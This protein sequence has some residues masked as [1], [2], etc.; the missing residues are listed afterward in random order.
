MF[1][2]G[3]CCYCLYQGLSPQRP[4]T[5][6]V[7]RPGDP[8]PCSTLGRPV[9]QSRPHSLGLQCRQTPPDKD[10]GWAELW[11]QQSPGRGRQ[12]PGRD[13]STV[14]GGRTTLFLNPSPPPPSILHPT[15]QP[16][17]LSNPTHPTPPI[18]TTFRYNHSKS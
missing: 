18:A 17:P 7:C 3:A 4:P 2:D 1:L 15:P 8:G 16:P 10:D 13:R 12:L 14:A 9:L 11:L 6:P 5:P